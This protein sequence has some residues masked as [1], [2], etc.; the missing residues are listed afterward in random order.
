VAGRDPK[1]KWR[2]NF[3]LPD[4]RKSSWVYLTVLCFIA[5][6]FVSLLDAPASDTKVQALAVLGFA[7]IS[8]GVCSYWAFSLQRALVS[9]EQYIKGTTA[10]RTLIWFWAVFGSIS[11]LAPK[12]G[13][14][15]QAFLPL[16]DSALGAF[17]GM[18]AVLLT[19]GPAYKEYREAMATIQRTTEP[20]AARAQP[21]AAPSAGVQR[22]KY[23]PG[24]SVLLIA[25]LTAAWVIVR[26]SRHDPADAGGRRRNLP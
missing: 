9:V 11:V 16:W 8:T 17:A 14:S 18:G 20:E 5:L 22:V 12:L 13:I 21:A 1:K 2:V 23:R 15:G 4:D 26:K 24:S 7:L 10:S 3:S 6:I 19:A 25:S